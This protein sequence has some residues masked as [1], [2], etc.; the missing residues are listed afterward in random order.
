VEKK[1]SMYKNIIPRSNIDFVNIIDVNFEDRSYKYSDK[2]IINV[3]DSTKK[4]HKKIFINEDQ[5]RSLNSLPASLRSDFVHELYNG[6]NEYVIDESDNF[7]SE[8][9]SEWEDDLSESDI[10]GTADDEE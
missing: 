2:T 5:A 10:L 1:T 7:Y 6:K 3:F 8:E 4:V 9:S